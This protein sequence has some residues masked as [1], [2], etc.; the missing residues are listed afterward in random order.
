MQVRMWSKVRGGGGQPSIAG[1]SGNLY[2]H[3]GNQCSG[4]SERQ[5]SIYFKIK[6]EH[7]WHIHRE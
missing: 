5:K 3:C 2:S 4:S 6:L 1:G 7:P